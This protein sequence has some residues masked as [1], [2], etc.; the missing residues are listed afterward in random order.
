[1]QNFKQID[2][3][4]ASVV[5]D[6]IKGLSRA[7]E[8]KSSTPVRLAVDVCFQTAVAASRFR[9]NFYDLSLKL[10]GSGLDG[11]HQLPLDAMALFT[12]S[13]GELRHE[14]QLAIH[15][16]MAVSLRP[17]DT[18]KLQYRI[19]VMHS[20]CIRL[21]EVFYQLD[22]FVMGVTAKRDA[23]EISGEHASALITRVDALLDAMKIGFLTQ[24]SRF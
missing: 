20:G 4:L 13:L 8:G 16:E 3:D 6:R 24:R 5:Y 7:L 19:C 17:F 21:L 15:Q 23:R 9:A 1:M 14:N 22:T 12:Q 18:A 11:Q 10:V 2:G